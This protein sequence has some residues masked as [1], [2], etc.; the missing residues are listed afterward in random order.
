M[1]HIYKIYHKS[2]PLAGAALSPT[3]SEDKSI[4]LLSGRTRHE[5]EEKAKCGKTSTETDLSLQSF[6]VADFLFLVTCGK[7]ATCL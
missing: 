1:T 5:D 2:C 6:S 7:S 4:M 3:D